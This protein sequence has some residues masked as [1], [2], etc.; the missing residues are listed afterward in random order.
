MN[1]DK[2]DPL[3]P[4]DLAAALVASLGLDA[5][6]EACKSN[7]S[8]GV[9]RVLLAD[10]PIASIRARGYQVRPSNLEPRERT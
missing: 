1:R 9:L 7:G 10:R 2:G 8:D 6:L 5:A 3:Y 4:R